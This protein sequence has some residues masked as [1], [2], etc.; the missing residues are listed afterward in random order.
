MKIFLYRKSFWIC[1]HAENIEKKM[2]QNHTITMNTQQMQRRPYI[3][4]RSGAISRN[5]NHRHLPRFGQQQQSHHNHR[6]NGGNN[7]QNRDLND[8]FNG[9]NAHG[10]VLQCCN[11]WTFLCY[12]G[13]RVWTVYFFSAPNRRLRDLN[14]RICKFLWVCFIHFI[15]ETLLNKVYSN[16]M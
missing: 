6:G 16:E 11:E 5:M 3:I 1:E 8:C 10:W 2:N 4:S 14:F 7:I 13:L 12:Q 9:H 15:K